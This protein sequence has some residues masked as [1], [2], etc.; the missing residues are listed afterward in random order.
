MM[1]NF[2]PLLDDVSC[3]VCAETKRDFKWVSR[4]MKMKTD[5]LDIR[6]FVR[7]RRAIVNQGRGSVAVSVNDLQGWLP[8]VAVAS[9]GIILV[10]A[11]QFPVGVVHADGLLI[12]T[13]VAANLKVQR[14]LLCAYGNLLG[15]C[16][17]SKKKGTGKSQL[18]EKSTVHSLENHGPTRTE[19]CQAVEALPAITPQHS[20]PAAVASES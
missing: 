3:L 16:W 7:S 14:E 10:I 1:D 20:R 5:C 2:R 13:A 6:C 11:L 15:Q 12:K 19:S 8:N 17:I 18:G 4:V 9:L